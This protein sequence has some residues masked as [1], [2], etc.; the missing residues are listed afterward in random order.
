M[1]KKMQLPNGTWAAACIPFEY[2]SW[3]EEDGIQKQM[4]EIVAEN[5]MLNTDRR[6]MKL[7]F[8][9]SSE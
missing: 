7:S 9:L 6:F 3:N 5:K 4:M 2:I 8:F 1:K